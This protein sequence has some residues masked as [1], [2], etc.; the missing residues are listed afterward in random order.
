[1]DALDNDVDEVAVDSL[2]SVVSLDACWHLAGGDGIR[3]PFQSTEYLVGTGAGA[4][5][6][7]VRYG[8][9]HVRTC[10]PFGAETRS[11]FSDL[12]CGFLLFGSAPVST[13]H[14][15]KTPM[16]MGTDTRTADTASRYRAG[17]IRRHQCRKVGRGNG[18][19]CLRLANVL[20]IDGTVPH[21][22]V[23]RE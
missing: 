8:D 18:G 16:D 9:P 22:R 14:S 19:G 15:D 2:V 20:R 3:S 7:A 11:R 5:S 17:P 10:N 23:W 6:A 12:L 21:R 4:F 13:I 1:M